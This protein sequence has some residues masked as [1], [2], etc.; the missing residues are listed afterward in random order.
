MA[1]RKSNIPTNGSCSVEKTKIPIS[2]PAN[3]VASGGFKSGFCKVAMNL[4]AE[5]KAEGL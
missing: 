5:K 2:Y 3:P 4:E 1:I